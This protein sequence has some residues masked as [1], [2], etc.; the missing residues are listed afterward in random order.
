MKLIYIAGAYTAPN[1]WQREQNIRAAESQSLKLWRSGVAAIC[2]HTMSRHFY[3][4]V[5]VEDAVRI[6]D[7]ILLRCDG[8]LLVPGWQDSHGTLR[9][10]EIA[11]ARGLRVFYPHQVQ[12]CIDWA[13]GPDA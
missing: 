7:A 1:A 9:E 3:G 11:K 12:D 4:E 5:R 13:G 2:V 6:D 8:V 10:L